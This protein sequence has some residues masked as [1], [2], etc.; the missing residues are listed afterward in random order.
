MLWLLVTL[1]LAK[2]IGQLHGRFAK[3]ML[4]KD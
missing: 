4:V 3:M 2:G 1:H